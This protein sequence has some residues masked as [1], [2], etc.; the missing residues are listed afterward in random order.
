MVKP[1]KR[2]VNRCENNPI[3]TAEDFP[4]DIVS[5]FNCGMTKR[6]GRYYMFTRCEDSSFGRYIWVCESDDGIAFTPRPISG[7]TQPISLDVWRLSE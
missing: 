5:A 1:L 2:I 6:D 7:F 4:G 3:L